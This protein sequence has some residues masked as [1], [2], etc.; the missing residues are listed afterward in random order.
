M[1][2]SNDLNMRMVRNYAKD[3]SQINIANG[4]AMKRV[5]AKAGE[6]K[7][8]YFDKILFY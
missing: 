2:F 8:L 5:E 3:D 1:E 4:F 6:T 7:S